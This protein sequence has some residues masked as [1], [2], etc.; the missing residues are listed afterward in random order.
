MS[1]AQIS[2]AGPITEELARGVCTRLDSARE[3]YHYP[4]VVLRI[5]SP[6]GELLGMELILRG[7]DR[8][9]L[10]GVAVRTVCEG[11]VASAGAVIASAGSPGLREAESHARL[12]YHEPRYLTPEGAHHTAGRLTSIASSLSDTTERMLE[13]LL[14]CASSRRGARGP[15]IRTANLTSRL[16]DLLRNGSSGEETLSLREAYLRLLRMDAW[17]TPEEACAFHLLDRC[18]PPL[19]SRLVREFDSASSDVESPTPTKEVLK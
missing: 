12:L 1:L 8:C 6:G 16:R 5:S 7:I 17:I 11:P 3:Y 18:V 15:V 9:H 14:H 10:A 4:E 2:I 19:R 13:A